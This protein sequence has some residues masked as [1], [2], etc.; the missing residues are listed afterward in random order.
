[1]T[2]GTGDALLC[3]CAGK[4]TIWGIGINLHNPSWKDV[5]N[6]RGNNNLGVILMELREEFRSE[7]LMFGSV[8]NADYSDAETIPVWN[9]T[10]GQLKRIPQ[11]YTAIH[12][13]SEQLPIRYLRNC[14]YYDYSLYDCEVAMRT[15]M[16]G[17][18]PAIGFWEMKQEVYE[19]AKRLNSF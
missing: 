15:N 13:Y 2:L 8:Q 19:I 7:L 4:D 9:L 12:T 6:W 5:R 14:F 17:G 3:E 18:L 10:A 1:M 16:G 11:Y